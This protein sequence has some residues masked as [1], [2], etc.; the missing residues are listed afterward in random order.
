MALMLSDNKYEVTGVDINPDLITRLEKKVFL[1]NEPGVNGLL[2]KTWIKFTDDYSEAISNSDVSFIVV[3][4]PSLKNGAFSLDYVLST[5]NKIA[6][7]LKDKKDWHLIVITSTIMPKSMIAIK[8]LLEKKTGKTIGKDI[9]L[10][11][12]PEFIALGSVIDNLSRP[13]FILIGQSDEKSGRVLEKIKLDLVKNLPLVKKTNHINA[14][15]AKL[16]LNSYIT[17]K[18]SFANL[19][20]RVCEIIPQADSDTITS[21]IGLDKRINPRYLKGGLGYGGPCFPRDNLA[22]A[23]LIKPLKI[24]TS[25]PITIDGFNRQQIFFIEK[26]V[27]KHI[28]K[29]KSL[30][31]L[32]LSYKPDTDVVDESQG[33]MLANLLAKKSYRVAVFDPAAMKNA[34]PLLDRKVAFGRSAQQ[35]ADDSDVVIVT[36]PWAQFSK[37]KFGKGKTVIDCWRVIKNRQNIKYIALGKHVD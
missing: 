37:L 9:G 21:T 15:I 16:A 36:T 32:G 25:L 34:I 8:S 22:F 6:G 35:I 1:S 26:I 13:D 20:A 29:K 14:E 23:N 4:T 17:T 33:I 24:K 2:A 19:I 10:C 18:I 12:S 28:T 27:K 30:G 3:P 31:I 5:V 7:E 11:Y